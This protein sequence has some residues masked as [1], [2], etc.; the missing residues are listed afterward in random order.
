MAYA[1]GTA[2]NYKDLLSI[3][4]TVA[5]A[6]GW[7]EKEWTDGI[8]LC[9]KGPGDAGLDEIYV[10]IEAYESLAAGYYNWELVGAWGYRA[11]RALVDHPRSSKAYRVYAQLWQYEIPYWIV[12]TGRRIILVAKISGTFQMIHLGLLDP[13]GTAEQYPYPLFIGG[14]SN[15]ETYPWSSTTLE[16]FWSGG[17]ALG[18]A[19]SLPGGQWQSMGHAQLTQSCTSVNHAQK[20]SILNAIDGSYMLEQIMVVDTNKVNIYGE[21]DGLFRVS[22]Y[23]NAAESIII[24]GGKNYL[25]V[26]NIY[27]ATIA[28][29][30]A[31]RLD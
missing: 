9:L 26:P 20:D 8:R 18:G 6:N 15:V 3:L 13:P 14:S 21:V 29:F 28:D 5:L 19:L 11:G 17:Y 1:S 4:R 27:R 30:C 31:L 7:V 10:G 23:N 16:A 24:A 22:G 12:V 25:V 2:A